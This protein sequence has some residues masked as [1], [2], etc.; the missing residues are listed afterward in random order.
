MFEKV[1]AAT[2]RQREEFDRAYAK[3]E[4]KDREGI[5]GKIKKR[6]LKL[7]KS[8]LPFGLRYTMIFAL[9]AVIVKKINTITVEEYQDLKLWYQEK[10]ERF[11][12]P[13]KN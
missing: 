1:E 7:L 2:Q 3:N 5:R 9:G 11:F 6:V 12:S 13:K 8:L 10:G 4:E